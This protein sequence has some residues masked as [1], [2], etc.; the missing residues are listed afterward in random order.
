MRK[1][2]AKAVKA[3]AAFNDGNVRVRAWFDIREGAICFRKK[4]SRKIVTVELRKVF[5]D[6]TGQRVMPFV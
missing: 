4:R 2:K 3:L 1:R 6:A 5:D